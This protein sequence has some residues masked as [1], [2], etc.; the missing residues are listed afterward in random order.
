M[1]RLIFWPVG[2]LCVLAGAAG[3][4]LPVLPGWALIFIGLTLVAPG[5]SSN[6][7]ARVKAKLFRAPLIELPAPKG[8]HMG[9]TTKRFG[10]KLTRCD[11]WENGLTRARF[12][13][14]FER[15]AKKVHIRSYAVLKQ[16]H[17]DRVQVIHEA[18]GDRR[19]VPL[20][21]SDAV[22]T[23]VPGVGLLALSADC[24]PVFLWTL[25]LGKPDWIG[26][27][28]AGWRGSQKGVAGQAFRRLLAESRSAPSDARAAFGPC[29]RRYEVGP[30][31]RDRFPKASLRSKGGR[32]HFDLAGE[33][34][35]QLVDAGLEPRR[36]HDTG[37]CTVA[38]NAD[39]P[40]FRL[41]GDASARIVS[42]IVKS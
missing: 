24:L 33:N 28:H 27:V 10:V 18:F 13:E 6:V 26:L 5:F 30:E 12:T 16:V 40:S 2:G 21:D 9:F 25:R 37:L 4:V 7:R 14:L 15:S 3:L 35:R 39:Y 17:G 41:E 31:F 32:L 29:I 19:T 34:R 11:D 42:Y 22:L 1:K 20:A 8:L 36:L 23:N 38:S